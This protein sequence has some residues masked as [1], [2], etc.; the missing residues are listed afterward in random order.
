MILSSSL[1][2][3]LG[4]GLVAGCV[5]CA[6]VTVAAQAPSTDWPQ[7]RGSERNGV[8]RET[9]LLR[10]WPRSGPA[11]VWSASQLGAGYGS[12]AVAGSRV[13]VQGMKNRQSVV[14]S[15]DRAAGKAAW[16]VAL[17]SAQENDRGSGPRSTPTVDSDRVYVLT[18][19]GDLVCLLAADG[20]IVWRRNIL[21]EFNG[22][23][24]NWLVSESPLIDGDRIIVSPGGRNAGM[25]ALDKMTGTTVWVSKELSDEAGYASS[26]VADVQGVRTIL[27]LTGHAGI[28]V[29]ATDGNVMW[30]YGTVAYNIA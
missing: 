8:S 21:R 19:S 25:V 13:F 24:I 11:V 1:S 6:V 18:E 2:R 15:L 9:G 7:W 29:R 22:R 23:N 12:V 30:R 27:T 17:G 5:A 4:L 26:V 3:R 10:E 20:K 16:S 14:T 28:G